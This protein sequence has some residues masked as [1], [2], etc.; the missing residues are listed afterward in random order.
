MQGLLIKYGEIALRGKNRH[1][2]EN[3]VID[4]LQKKLPNNYIV[5]KEQGRILIEPTN[6]SHMDYEAIIPM[7]KN[8][9]GVTYV[10]PCDIIENKDIETIK[11]A[12]IN[13]M[14]KH[15]TKPF[16]F[17][18]Q[19]KRSNKDY[20]LTSIEINQMVG[21]AVLD[22]NPQATVDVNKPE[23][24]V[25]IELRTRCYIF[26]KVIKGI[27]GLPQVGG[28]K[29]LVMLSGGIDSPVAAYLIAR[30]GVEIDAIYF[31]APPYTSEH[32]KQ[33][34]VDL[35]H[36]LAYFTGRIKLH[37]VNFT[38]LQLFLYEKVEQEKLTIH[39]KRAMVKISQKLA[40]N[41]NAQAIVM[42][43]SVGQVASQTI[44]SIQA[45]D[46]IGNG[47][48][49]LRPLAA[50]D[51]QDIVD[52]AEQIETY[53]IS[54]LPYEDCCTIFVAKHPTTRPHLPAIEKTEARIQTEIDQHIE[55]AMSDIEIVKINV[56]TK[57]KSEDER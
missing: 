13:Y 44:Y 52:I 34:V 26:S 20:P 24:L 54:I 7:A 10:C 18:I 8:T 55:K 12:T 45:I 49:I 47:L 5:K 4:M 38:P 57:L 39:L 3:K 15:Y 40:H 21:G 32:A 42:G 22:S 25:H 37:I 50:H 23:A 16:T 19:T 31:H 56:N 2:F 29:A 36:R 48:P 6:D 33:K 17:K 28:G 9:L 30:R 1:L 46:A 53:P 41:L 14:A 11:T 51:K 43:D 35:C 27:G